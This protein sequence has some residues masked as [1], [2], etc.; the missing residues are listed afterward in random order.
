[1]SQSGKEV[2]GGG[3][4]RP[5]PAKDMDATSSAETSARIRV[6]PNMPTKARRRAMSA[7]ANPAAIFTPAR[8]HGS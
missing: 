3:S 2:S 5:P 6:P 8:C 1:M 4:A 7:M